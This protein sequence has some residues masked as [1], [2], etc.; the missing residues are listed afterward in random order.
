TAAMAPLPPG[1]D[2]GTMVYAPPHDKTADRRR[3]GLFVVSLAVLLALL[4]V[5][6]VVFIQLV[7]EED[8]N[9]TAATT[10]EQ[11]DVPSVFQLPEAEAIREL[12][13]LGLVTESTYAENATVAEGVVF[14]Q[15]PRAGSKVD[16]GSVVLLT[17]SQG[18]EAQ[19]VPGV[20]GQMAVDAQRT[21]TEQGFESQ[22]IQVEDDLAPSGQVVGQSPEAGTQEKPGTV[23]TLSISTGPPIVQV[24]DVAGQSPEEARIT[25]EQSGFQVFEQ[26]ESSSAFAEGAVTR[27]DPPAGTDLEKGQRVTMF[28]STGIDTAIVPGVVGADPAS[29]VG[30]LQ[31]SGFG[32]QQFDTPAEPGEIPGTVVAQDPGAGVELP[33]GSTVNIWVAVETEIPTPEPT[34]EPTATATPTATPTA[35]AEPA[36]QREQSE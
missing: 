14:D 23:V 26:T 22:L 28:I 11:V 34:G 13:S 27:T 32:V 9:P 30:A 18:A 35:T 21:L 16:T 17:V 3:S 36:R 5:L 8:E 7:G 31:A 10:S 6:V 4:A 24:P 19:P 29:A 12:E 15:D 2:P 20:V 33:V 1:Y 25:L